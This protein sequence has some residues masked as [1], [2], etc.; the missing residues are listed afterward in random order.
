MNL[1]LQLAALRITAMRALQATIGFLLLVLLWPGVTAA[2]AS[3]QIADLPVTK[4]EAQLRLQGDA[5]AVFEQLGEIYQVRLLVD[6]DF[7]AKKLT[8]KLTEVDFATALKLATELANAFWVR[9]DER[10]FLI[11]A[12][13]PEKRRQY[14]PQLVQTFSLAGSSPEELAEVVRLLREVFDMRRIQP[15]ARTQTFTVR[16]TPERLALASELVA[17]LRGERGEVLLEALLIEVDRE[18][19]RRLGLLPPQQAAMVHLGVGLVDFE[20]AKSLIEILRPL[21]ERGLIPE[22]FLGVSLQTLLGA[23][24]MDPAALQAALPP[25]ILFGGGATT[26]AATLPGATLNLMDIASV[27]RSLRRVSLRAHHAEEASILVGERFPVVMATFSSL[28]YPPEVLEL[29]KRGLFIPPVPA[30]QYED[31]GLRFSARSHLHAG[32]EVTLNLKLELRALTAA[33]LNAIPILSIRTIEQSARLKAGETLLLSGF[34]GETREE[35]HRGTPLLGSIPVIG[36]L[37]SRREP[38]RHD[39]ELLLLL[40]PHILRPAVLDRAGL[41]TLYAGPEPRF[42]PAGPGPV[43]PAPPA[44]PPIPPPRPPTQ[45]PPQN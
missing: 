40:T 8:L 19:A 22:A 25:F 44:Q 45:P 13:T 5:R 29:I 42:S 3:D 31:L 18:R 41:R 16:D 32:G 1:L 28:F 9:L 17:Q 35:V 21:L 20:Q 10:T 4:K 15:D 23:L 39:T 7:P 27:T 38:Q 12:N 14:E 26:F 36:H 2:V 24:S 33:S 37:F 30:V 6:E 34:L 43:A 11:A